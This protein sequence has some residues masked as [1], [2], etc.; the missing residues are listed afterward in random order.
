LPVVVD[1]GVLLLEASVVIAFV[2]APTAAAVG[3]LNRWG[4][5]ALL[6]VLMLSAPVGSVLVHLRN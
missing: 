1:A 3:R 5:R 6:V 4:Y 2:V